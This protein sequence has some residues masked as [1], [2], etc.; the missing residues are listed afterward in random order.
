MDDDRIESAARWYEDAVFGGD[1]EALDRADQALDSVE[2]DLLLA[3]GRVVHARFLADRKENPEELGL[4]ERSAQL[5][6]ELGDER[7]E[8]EALFWVGCCHQVVHGDTERA[9]P[10]FERS[11][12]LAQH[13]GDR[14]TL[15]YAVRHLGFA[16]MAAG[17][18][19]EARALFEESVRLREEIGFTRGV[20]AGKFALAELAG[21]VG[22]RDEAK[23]LLDEAAELAD[24]SDAG[25]L[26]KWIEARRAAL[27]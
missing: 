14:L 12:E 25:R 2:A 18:M 23:R 19:D 20:A 26:H 11:R 27:N 15:S 9:T 7:G 10:C 5:Y 21:E 13:S 24:R 4:F 1:T 6:R 17:R 16:E 3:R 8:A 22:D